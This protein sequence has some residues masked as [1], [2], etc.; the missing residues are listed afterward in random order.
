MAEELIALEEKKT[1]SITS[2]PPGKHAVGS[3]WIFKT[4]FK[5]DGTID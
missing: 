4:K 5:S 3:R 2:L 1:W